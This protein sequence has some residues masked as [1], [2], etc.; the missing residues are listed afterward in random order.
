M[1]LYNVLKFIA[2]IVFNL[3]YKIEVVGLENIPEKEGALICPNHYTWAD[4]VIVGI[5][6]PRPIRFMAK[7]EA[8]KNPFLRFLLKY[9]GA[10]P[11]RRGEADLNAVKNTLKLL[12]EG[13]LVGLFPQGT[14]VK[15]NDLG[16]AHSGVALFAIKSGKK[17]I[18]VYISGNYVPFTKMRVV[19]GK[20]IDFSVYSKDKLTGDDYFNLSQ[21]VIQKIRELKEGEN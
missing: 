17:V 13:N 21:I 4:P 3:I 16:K 18:P 5:V 1:V 11:V 14:R 12:K 2:K 8:F 7:V 15:G 20:P 6:T 9:L 19:F 10:Y